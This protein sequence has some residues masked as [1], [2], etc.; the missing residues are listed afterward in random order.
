MT[1]WVDAIRPTTEGQDGERIYDSWDCPQV[2]CT[3]P[4]A[5]KENDEL[6]L[7][8][9]DKMD[10]LT[11]NVDGELID[12]LEDFIKD[13]KRQADSRRRVQSVSIVFLPVSMHRHQAW[14][15]KIPS[16]HLIAQ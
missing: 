12:I 2:V 10:V 7:Q 5:A 14:A 11:K 6:T 9:N 15:F 4:Y 16:I 1:R 13:L 8:L 3:K